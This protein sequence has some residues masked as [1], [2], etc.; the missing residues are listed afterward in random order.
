MTHRIGRPR[1]PRASGRTRPR[2]AAGLLAFL[3]LSLGGC[4][5]IEW[6]GRKTNLPQPV[7]ESRRLRP[8]ETTLR[9]ALEL[10]GPPDLLVQTGTVDRIYY[11]CWD[12]D[13]VKLVVSAPILLAARRSVDAFI[14]GFGSEELRLVRLE[15]DRK[16][17]L[18]DLQRLDTPLS[19]NG[20]Y[21]ALDN[22]IVQNFLEDRERALRVARSGDE[23]GVVDRDR[24]DPD[25]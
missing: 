16:G 12:S 10:L 4:V 18:Q 9:Q 25:R 2:G 24:P 3:G 6:E 14:L 19:R 13:Y 17:I 20:Q 1:K 11:T 7:L 15:F 22:Q 8:G 23:D 5:S 21:V